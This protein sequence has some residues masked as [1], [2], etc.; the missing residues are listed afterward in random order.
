MRAL[1]TTEFEIIRSHSLRFSRG[2]ATPTKFAP[3]YY[4]GLEMTI[5]EKMTFIKTW[6]FI[7]LMLASFRLSLSMTHLLELPQL[8]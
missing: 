2:E 8:P 3:V 4:G 6:Q 1:F 7:T 5:E